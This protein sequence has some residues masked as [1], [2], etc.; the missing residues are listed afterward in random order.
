MCSSPNE[1]TQVLVESEGV[2]YYVTVDPQVNV[3]KA[4]ALRD[5]RYTRLSD[6]VEAAVLFDLGE[7]ELA[8]DFSRIWP[9]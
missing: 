4:Y 7:C 6:V 3:A 9:E 8:F 1:R 5:G 2:R